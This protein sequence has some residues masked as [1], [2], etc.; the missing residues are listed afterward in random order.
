MAV[1]LL[2][3]VLANVAMASFFRIVALLAPNKEAEQTFPGPVIALF[4]IFAGFLITPTK[5]GFLSFMYHVSLFAYALRS[6]CQ[7]EFLS[8]S[9]DK[10]VAKNPAEYILY[11]QANP[12]MNATSVETLCANGA[13]ECS[14]M[15]EAIMNQIPS[16][17]TAVLLGRC[18][19]VRGSGPSA[20]S[21]AA[22][23]EEGSDSDEHRIV[24]SGHRRRDRGGGQ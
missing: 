7:N 15:G 14:T 16:T 8:S 9:Y 1:L 21:D 13:F 17:T 19:D 10:V 5:M 23:A 12:G 6:L 3:L 4:L 22:G 11:M 18:Q 20:S 24:P 2:N